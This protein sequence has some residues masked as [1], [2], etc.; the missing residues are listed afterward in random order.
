MSTDLEEAAVFSVQTIDIPIKGQDD[1]LSIDCRDLPA[2]PRELCDFL[3]NEEADAKYW[4]RVAVEYRNQNMFDQATDILINGLES[5]AIR[6]TGQRRFPFH[7]L[8]AA[9]YIERGRLAPHGGGREP[10]P[11]IL[12]KDYWQRLATQALNEAARINPSSPVNQLA[13]GVLSSMR[14]ET[15]RNLE[16]ARRAYDQSNRPPRTNLFA[17]LG[18]ARVLY[19]RKRYRDALQCYQK[20]LTLRP[21]MVPDPRIGIGLC[22]WQLNM[23]S[24]ALYAFERAMELD[25]HNSAAVLLAGI[26][27]IHRAFDHVRD[28][29]LFQDQYAAGVRLVSRAYKESRSPLAGTILASYYFATRKMTKLTD[30][31][32]EALMSTD[33]PSVRADALFWLG[34][35]RHLM[36]QPVEAS[37]FYNLARQLEP[38]A[39]PILVGIGQ[40]QLARG[41]ITDAKL[42]FESVIEKF[43][44]CIEALAALGNLYMLE[45]L[46]SAFKGDLAIHKSKARALLDRAIALTEENPKRTFTEPSLQLAKAMVADDDQPLQTLRVLEQAAE[47]QSDNAEQIS[48]EILNNMAVLQTFAGNHALAK[49]LYSRAIEDLR[50]TEQLNEALFTL[51][52]FNLGRCEEALGNHTAAIEIYNDL[53]R[54]QPAFTNAFARLAYVKFTTGQQNEAQSLFEQLAGNSELNI[55]TRALYGWYLN[56]T[57]IIKGLHYNE[58]PERRHFNTTLK[59]VD[60]Y[61][62]YALTSL[63]NFYLRLARET[64]SDSTEGQAEKRK[65]YDMAIKFL[66]RALHYD[67]GNAYAAQGLAIAFAE[68]RE[69][70]RALSIFS[71]VRETLRDES[72]FLNMGHCLAELRQYA[73]AIECYETCL[74]TFHA[75]KDTMLHQCLGRAWLARGRE[76]RDIDALRE[77]LRYTKLAQE[78][79]PDNA[80]IAF[81]VAFV[82]F[83]MAEVLRNLPEIKRTVE[84]LREAAIGLDEAVRTF[85]KLA[86]SKHAPYSREDIKQRATMG[87]NTT[88]RQIERAI[89]QQ[90]EYEAR[91]SSKVEEARHRREQDKLERERQQAEARS[92]DAIRQESLRE[93]RRKMQQEAMDWAEKRRMQ[94]Q[95]REEH[96]REKE[97]LKKE[98]IAKRK[99]RKANDDAEMSDGLDKLDSDGELKRR[100]KGKRNSRKDESDTDGVVSDADEEILPKKRSRGVA[101]RKDQGR[102]KKRALR[103]AND[104]RSGDKVDLGSLDEDMAEDSGDEE[105]HAKPMQRRNGS[106]RKYI[107][108]EFVDSDIDDDEGLDD[109]KS[110]A[111]AIANE[112]MIAS[113]DEAEAASHDVLRELPSEVPT[114]PVADSAASQPANGAP[115]D[116]ARA[117]LDGRS[118]DS[119][120]ANEE[121]GVAIDGTTDVPRVL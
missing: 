64:R 32:D 26:A 93:E 2:D 108:S 69:F 77:A 87:K 103:R 99:T 90:V 7:S 51:L 113:D 20:V 120:A 76:E 18:R 106:S 111:L 33:M 34:R 66:E 16:E 35:A 41:E 104:N 44:K 12:L 116:I 75:G 110:S 15:D 22:F 82:Q 65:H 114:I 4:L 56:K 115:A 100:R 94:E 21:N 102:K 47:I 68:H 29:A 1:V 117:V 96:E 71:K 43:P 13:K 31:L 37:S 49:D 23:H 10:G 36:E 27:E 79:Q 98:R 11:G 30:V 53:T 73:R 95:E 119:L 74:H 28:P 25:S 83:Q 92:A 85:N 52:S 17:L 101:S 88:S 84:D 48:P 24:E 8:L 61:E 72:T 70:Q 91:N 63:G 38:D 59:H 121:P 67:A 50:S 57:K 40:M 42:T 14:I 105:E 39:L 46:D 3:S 54:Q 80:A 109:E 78:T 45:A 19:A 97:E 58:D 6:A 118:K 55:E 62:R 112:S 107:S 60:N 9:I 89:Q 5:P 81:N 86:E